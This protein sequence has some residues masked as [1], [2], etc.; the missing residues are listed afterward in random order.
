MALHGLGQYDE[1]VKNYE[2]GIK[3][4]PENAQLK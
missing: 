2:E 1:A 3:L 4:D